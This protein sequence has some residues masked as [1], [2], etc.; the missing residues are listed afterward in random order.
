MQDIPTKDYQLLPALVSPAGYICLIRDVEYQNRFAIIRVQNPSEIGAFREKLVFN[1]KIEK[2]FGLTQGAAKLERMLLQR[3]AD[4]DDWFTLSPA[5]LR[6]FG[7]LTRQP[8][9]G[10]QPPRNP[11]KSKRAW[12]NLATLVLVAL[13]S[14]VAL[15]MAQDFGAVI[16]SIIRSTPVSSAIATKKPSATPVPPSATATSKPSTTSAPPSATATD[17]SL[18]S[19]TPSATATETSLSSATPSAS[20]EPSA[21][22]TQKP[23]P[24]SA[25]TRQIMVVETRNNLGANARDCPRKTC[26]I[27]VTLRP[28]VQIQALGQVEGEEVYGSATWVQFEYKGETAYIHSELLEPIGG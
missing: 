10:P 2:I 14:F 4:S 20:P 7:S 6:E 9:H 12:R 21:T 8:N 23:E 27:I 18:P 11:P 17:T 24:S 22:S 15:S 3:Y 5:Q 26:A 28:D 13:I 16:D 1:T 19:V 25:P